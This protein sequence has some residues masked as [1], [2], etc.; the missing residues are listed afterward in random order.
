MGSSPQMELVVCCTGTAERPLRTGAP[1]RSL[2]FQERRRRLRAGQAARR[3]KGL[4][5]ATSASDWSER[6]FKSF[7]APTRLEM[8]PE[9]ILKK[10]IPG[11]VFGS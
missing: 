10:G 11:Y 3:P 4:W 9:S 6:F 7:D 2:P 1:P 8:A 5:L